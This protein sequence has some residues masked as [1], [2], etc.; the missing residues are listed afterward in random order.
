[1]NNKELRI[2]LIEANTV[3]LLCSKVNEKM[4][5]YSITHNRMISYINNDDVFKSSF[6]SRFNPF[7]IEVVVDRIV[8]RAVDNESI[9][10]RY[11]ER[12]L[13][14]AKLPVQPNQI[15]EHKLDVVENNNNFI[16]I[17]DTKPYYKY[18]G[19]RHS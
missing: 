4:F 19:F 13:Q 8:K 17:N 5:P 18:G 9:V 15:L 1:M 10:R 6:V 11:K 16:N 7:Q 3:E 12:N 14:S 2:K